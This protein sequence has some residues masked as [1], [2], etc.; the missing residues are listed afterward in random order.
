MTV[1]GTKKKIGI[2][3]RGK[4][5]KNSKRKTLFCYFYETFIILSF[6][7]SVE[8]IDELSDGRV[9]RVCPVLIQCHL[10]EEVQRRDIVKQ[11]VFLL[12]NEQ[13]HFLGKMQYPPQRV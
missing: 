3:I 1:W 2:I 12:G 10:S 8:P 4:D 5:A 7:Y 11:I 6:S 9:A 13:R